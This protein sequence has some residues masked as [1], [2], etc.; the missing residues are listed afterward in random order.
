MKKY[1]VQIVVSKKATLPNRAAFINSTLY[2]FELIFEE[3][4][5][6]NEFS[7]KRGKQPLPSKIH[8]AEVCSL[9]NLRP[10]MYKVEIKIYWLI[11]FFYYTKTFFLIYKSNTKIYYFLNN[12]T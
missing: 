5:S 11:L 7:R 6:A 4:P 12:I 1:I 8:Y 9:S 10:K 3:L 2:I